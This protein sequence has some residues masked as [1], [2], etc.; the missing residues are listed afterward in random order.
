[1]NTDEDIEV[2]HG[3]GVIFADL[4]LLEPEELPAKAALGLQ[5]HDAI[6][7]RG[8]TRVQA[9]AAL[10]IPQP[11]VCE[12]AQPFLEVWFRRQGVRRCYGE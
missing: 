4:G 3:S 7:E 8:W 6:V 11:R 12:R 10:G 5:I 1:M 2:V 9:A